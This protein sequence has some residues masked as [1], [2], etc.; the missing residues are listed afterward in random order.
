MNIKGDRLWRSLMD[1]ARIGALPLGGSCR[2]ALSPEDGAGRD[3]FISWCE[4]AGC[5][6]RIDQIGNLYARRAGRDQTALAVA[7]GSHLDTQPHGGK[8]D[9]VFGVLAGLEVLRTLNDADVETHSPIEVVV[10]TNEEGARFGPPLTGSS[11]YAGSLPL[12]AAHQATTV[13]GTTVRDDLKALGFLGPIVPGANRFACFIE[14]HI[15]QGPILENQ[16]RTIG[17]VTHV[18]GIRWIEVTVTGTDGHAGT[19]PMDIRRDAL[20]AATQM[21][22]QLYDA[23][24]GA[25][26]LLRFTVGKMDVQPN[27]GAT[28]PGKVTFNCDLRH[29]D[30]KTMDD[31]ES[32]LTER[33]NAV[34]RENNVTV[35]LERMIDIPPT[36][37][38]EAIV[39]SI[40]SAA[41][42]SGFDPLNMLS[43][44]GHDAMN[45]ART[46]PAGMIFVPCK[47]GISHNEAESAAPDDLAAGTQVLLHTLLEH[48]RPV[49]HPP[50]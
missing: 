3:L 49:V 37:F 42:A 48:A 12:A 21:I 45:V 7:T 17:V 13:D 39:R 38:D 19:T 1:M 36:A 32:V 43:G 20:R 44:A 33:L 28:I 24:S 29:P 40:R 41:D 34:A 9:G 47:D 35:S 14:A 10:W 16:G 23:F 31:L 4:E 15:E 8:F 5:E 6:V 26:D 27:S 30:R 11:V 46:A 50:Y 22:T 18:Q 25:G 2:T